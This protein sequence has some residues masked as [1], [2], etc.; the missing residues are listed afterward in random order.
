MTSYNRKNFFT[1]QTDN[2]GVVS[3]DPVSFDFREIFEFFKTK[4]VKL[5]RISEAEEA[6]PELISYQEYGTHQYW[7]VIMY[8][9]KLQDPINE[10]TAGT[11]IAIPSLSDVEEFRQANLSGQTRGETVILR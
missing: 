11:L 3:T 9:N 4:Q 5:R 2:N 6:A 10:L 8:L 7:W 1:T